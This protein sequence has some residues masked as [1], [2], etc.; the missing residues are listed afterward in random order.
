MLAQG[1]F[2]RFLPLLRD[3]HAKHRDAKLAE[4]RVSFFL[5]RNGFKILE[6][7]PPGANGNGGDLRVQWRETKPIFVEIKHPN[8]HGELAPRTKRKQQG[9]TTEQTEALRKRLAQPKDIDG[10]ARW[11]DPVG[12]AMWV[13]DENALKKL[14]PDRPNLL[15]VADDFFVTPIDMP[16]LEVDV[17]TR[18]KDPKYERVGGILFLKPDLL[19]RGVRYRMKFIENEN[20]LPSCRLPTEVA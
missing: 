4:A 2:D 9:L 7:D 12:Q 17:K 18:L 8:W 1:Q 11:I 15:V 13:L 3:V 19:D 10:E 16:N 6:Y 5:H 20:A 14:H